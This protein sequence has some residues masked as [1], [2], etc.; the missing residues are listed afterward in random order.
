MHGR[1]HP[2]SLPA[3]KRRLSPKPAAS[4]ADFQ[5]SPPRKGI[6]RTSAAGE[7]AAMPA[8][9]GQP[10]ATP[11][12]L[13]SPQAFLP[14]K[15]QKSAG[16]T[17]TGGPSGRSRTT[18][19]PIT[20][21][22]PLLSTPTPVEKNVGA[23]SVRST[24]HEG[25]SLATNSF[26]AAGSGYR[27]VNRTSESASFSAHVAGVTSTVRGERL[28]ELE[29]YVLQRAGRHAIMT[30]RQ[31]AV[32]KALS[33]LPTLYPQL[34]NILDSVQR[35][36]EDMAAQVRHADD[37][38]AEA[39]RQQEQKLYAKFETF[40][41]GKIKELVL[42][43]QKAEARA[44]AEHAAAYTVRKERDTELVE[45]KEELLERLNECEH[46]EDQFRD[47]R[48]LI[49]SV[50]QTN[51][52]LTL[53]IDQLESVLA[54]H[55]IDIPPAS[56]ELSA[57]KTSSE[58]Q[59]TGAGRDGANGGNRGNS[60]TE[61]RALSTQVS[62][63]FLA[64]T[65]KEL[66]KSRLTLQQELLHS[67]FDDHSAYRLRIAGLSRENEDLTFRI[68]E[69][70]EKVK[71]LYTYIHEK[72]FFTQVDEYGNETTPL[73]P[74]P[75]DVPLA[76]QSEL[77][78]ELRHSTA[79]ILTELSTV[80]INMKHQ[81][82]SALLRARQLHMLSA[83]LNEGDITCGD[84]ASGVGVVGAMLEHV[85]EAAVIPVFPVA[86]WPS[87][88]HFL[89]TNVSPE[90]RNCFWTEAQAGC[91]LYN[92]FVSYKAVRGRAR[93]V[94][95]G[96]MLAPRVYQP[97]EHRR[98]LLTR[99]D[100]SKA[101][102]AQSEEKIPFGYVVSQFAREVLIQLSP[103]STQDALPLVL[104][105]TITTRYPLNPPAR[106]AAT[107]AAAAAVEAVNSKRKKSVPARK[108]VDGEV[109]EKDCEWAEAAPVVELD[110]T[111]FTY[112]MWY[113]AMRYQQTQPLC[114]LFVDL[115]DG[116]LPLETFDVMEN[117]LARVQRLV[118]Q[119]DNDRSRRF[120]YQRLVNGVVRWVKDAGAQAVLRG[121]QA[122]VQSFESHHSV[123]HG[124][125]LSPLDLFADETYCD[126]EEMVSSL[127]TEKHEHKQRNTV[128]RASGTVSAAT[129][130]VPATQEKPRTPLP[131][132][133]LIRQ[134]PLPSV[135]RGVV[136]SFALAPLGATAF[137][138]HWRRF[139]RDAL[140]EVYT[141]IET[142]LAPLVEES[143]VVIGLHL[144]S[145]PR[146]QAVLAELDNLALQAALRSA[147]FGG[148]T[149]AGSISFDLTGHN[150][151][152]TL[153]GAKLVAEAAD[154][155]GVHG[156]A[157][158]FLKLL[159]S[160]RGA[161]EEK[162]VVERQVATETVMKAVSLLPRFKRSTHFPFQQQSEAAAAALR[163]ELEAAEDEEEGPGVDG[164][165]SSTLQQPLLPVSKGSSPSTEK[166][167]GKGGGG[168][169]VSKES[170]KAA[171]PPRRSAKKYFAG[172]VASPTDAKGGLLPNTS[173]QGESRTSSQR[174]KR[175]KALK[176]S[177]SARLVDDSTL[178]ELS[179]QTGRPFKVGSATF[180]SDLLSASEEGELVEWYRLRHML[181]QTMPDFP[182]LLF[183]P[184]AYELAEEAEALSEYPVLRAFEESPPTD[185][186]EK[187]R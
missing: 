79:D 101:E 37:D 61:V 46:T 137:V 119:L 35:Y 73:T 162:K 49:A 178:P 147:V 85:A 125:T 155:L 5:S 51:Q 21:T 99:L 94:R 8:S 65:N 112:N 18:A 139:V 40:F 134:L 171:I 183:Q 180:A 19:T 108:I 98:V 153:T 167:N 117:V 64:A 74:R 176:K 15:H 55:R 163:Q 32:Q 52:Q 165:P 100:A 146:A 177:S 89:R 110:W 149:S 6:S 3:L 93:F 179:S 14:Q 41:E 150:P 87:V 109:D 187:E 140:E 173:E 4:Q 158:S 164:G 67:A 124:G 144:L 181:R 48:H 111:R 152:D 184:D 33:L 31:K 83:W 130:A 47:F 44:E 20:S 77:G 9:Y 170:A 45:V 104:P 76:L 143:E 26:D 114:Q 69:L 92:F 11:A 151:G 95:D 50:F 70:E 90:V 154:L 135:G 57:Y 102:A 78:I 160:R 106:G 25:Q 75:R 88:P 166:K 84:A 122:V 71:D 157:R 29:D 145:V 148:S 156:V 97:F 53:R 58:V 105:G 59:E 12:T 23:P 60:G 28:K 133:L 36:T 115:V 107:A 30:E 185:V 17:V 56:T 68:S 96:K 13:D 174:P 62:V 123:I 141:R 22:S 138:R 86:S 72:R 2:N 38:K 142:V 127:P 80:A 118:D 43:R 129:S 54:R 161:Q 182:F 39:L 120:S 91:I 63:A 24:P 27:A 116:R 42:A 66:V 81:L 132:S 126:R 175:S 169:K 7:A 82:N 103:Q 131:G 10:W 159:E 186:K 34:T 113:A 1:T 121:V 172:S 128:V 168:S 136:S 16:E